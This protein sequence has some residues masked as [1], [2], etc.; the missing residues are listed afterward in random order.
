MASKKP[1]SK[2]SRSKAAEFLQK[3]RGIVHPRV[4]AAGGPQFFGIVSVDCAKARSKWMLAD[5]F[6]NVLVAAA[7]S[8]SILQSR[9]ARTTAVDNRIR[10]WR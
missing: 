4:Q 7:A 9:G 10:G 8:S 3:P 6:G 2:K 5:F 1:R